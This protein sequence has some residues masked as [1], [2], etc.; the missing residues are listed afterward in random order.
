MDCTKCERPIEG[1]V[2]EHAVAVDIDGWREEF[3]HFECVGNV[4][5]LNPGQFR[6]YSAWWMERQRERLE[7]FTEHVTAE[8]AMI[9]RAIRALPHHLNYGYVDEIYGEPEASARE[10]GLIA[11]NCT[12]CG[13]PVFYN[14]ERGRDCKPVL[15]GHAN[16]CQSQRVA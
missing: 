16:S 11:G 14:G 4:G 1:D 12:S 9:H 15:V 8:L 5:L 3:V 6:K 10:D 2:Y 7:A 13:R